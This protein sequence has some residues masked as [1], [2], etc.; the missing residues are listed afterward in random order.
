MVQES[1]PFC[2]IFSYLELHCYSHWSYIE[3]YIW[4]SASSLVIISVGGSVIYLVIQEIIILWNKK[5]TNDTVNNISVK[6][7]YFS[8]E[9]PTAVF[10]FLN[11]SQDWGMGHLKQKSDFSCSS[12]GYIKGFIRYKNIV[13]SLNYSTDISLRC[14]KV[15]M[16][17]QLYSTDFLIIEVSEF[18]K[19]IAWLL[20]F[21]AYESC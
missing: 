16:A 5:N 12:N 4:S 17:L 18:N 14:C 20:S 2:C 3:L 8:D 11:D 10:F 9:P 6:S 7:E 21:K 1:I 19:L 13:F 15:S